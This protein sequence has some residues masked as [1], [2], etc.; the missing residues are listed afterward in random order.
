MSEAA[1]RPCHRKTHAELVEA[2]DRLADERHRQ[3]S[4]GLD[5]SFM[6]VIVP[7]ALCLFADCNP[8]S[9]L[10]IGSGTGE[11]TVRL[12]GVA[13]RVVAVEP[14]GRSVA[15][16]R[17]ACESKKNVEFVEA[18]LEEAALSGVGA[19][20]AVAVMS[21]MTTPTLPCFARALAGVLGRD[22]R[23]VAVFTHPWFWPKYW[24]Y[25]DAAWYEYQRE[26]F[27]EAGFKTSTCRTGIVTTHIHRPLEQ[28]VR[29]FADEGFV[30]EKLVEPMPSPEVHALYPR[31]WA[32]PRFIGL[33]WLKT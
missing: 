26:I 5:L 12:A 24:G 25:D 22:A 7:T 6:H 2:W 15:I 29:V 8:A 27:V 32:F 10:D 20:A 19:T 4:L 11:F 23:F 13:D 30:L 33:R 9:V 17:M 1:L 18:P 3:I 21:L 31:R 16:A 14:S 28:Y